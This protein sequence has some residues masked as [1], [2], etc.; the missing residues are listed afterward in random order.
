[1]SLGEKLRVVIATG[2]G[3]WLAVGLIATVA[4]RVL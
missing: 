3:S 1:M 2:L 4:L